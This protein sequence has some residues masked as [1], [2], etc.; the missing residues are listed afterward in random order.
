MALEDIVTST[1]TSGLS[2]AGEMGSEELVALQKA[3]TA[4]YGSDTNGLTGGSAFRIQSLDTTLKA[5]V[6]ENKHFALFNALAKPKAT[7]VVDEW[8]EQD[9]IGG[10]LGGTFNDQDGAASETNGSYTRR[11]AQVKYM[12][13]YR[14][15]PIVLQ[16]QNNIVDAVSVETVNGTKQLLTDIEFSLF[17]GDDTVTPKSFQGIYQQIA[18]YQSG[19]NIIDMAGAPLNSIDPIARAAEQVFGYGSFGVLTD[20]YLPPAIQTDLNISLDPA[21]R[22]ALD[23][24]PNS[25]SLGTTVRAIQ[26]TYGAIA[27]RNDVFIRDERMKKPFEVRGGVHAAVATANLAFKPASFT[28]VAGAG[29]ADSAFA[30]AHA[31]NYYYAVTGINQNG[32]T[33]A[34]VSAVVAVTAGQQV[35]VTISQS[36]GQGETGYV[37]YRSRKNGTNA[38]TDLRE[39]TRVAKAGATT[40]FIDKN[41]IIPGS[42]RAYALNLTAGDASIDWKQYLPMMKI[43]MAAVN[44]P[45]IPWLQMICGYL[46]VTKRAHHVVF[47]NVVPTGAAWKPFV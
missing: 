43:P 1:G 40:A 42:T 2:V 16:S 37:I 46:R 41:R 34:L 7:A 21:F 27:T 12:T 36:A 5:T 11:T 24:T 14:K 3:L 19:S 4:G 29:G 38:L 47:D 20:L 31:G 23:N 8:T 9:S 22:V 32:E 17:E 44:S 10:F 28:A 15:I 6:Q 33:A 35:T 45:I 39:M 13:T 26:T 25:I 18:S 30:A